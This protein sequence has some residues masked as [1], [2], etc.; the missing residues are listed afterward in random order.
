MSDTDRRQFMKLTGVG[1]AG[2]AL[3]TGTGVQTTATS[4]S[5]STDSI[6]TQEDYESFIA[7]SESLRVGV[8][9]TD[10]VGDGIE[11]GPETTEEAIYISGD[12]S[13]NSWSADTDDVG[14]P[15]LVTVLLDIIDRDEFDLFEILSEFVSE[16]D[17]ALLDAFI[18][19][20]IDDLDVRE[21]LSA[22]DTEQLFAPIVEILKGLDL[23]GDDERNG[24]GAGRQI[25]NELGWYLGIQETFENPDDLVEEDIEDLRFENT[26]VG[27]QVVSL[28][29]LLDG[30]EIVVIADELFGGK[31][32]DDPVAN[33]DSVD[34]LLTDPSVDKFIQLFDRIEESL[35]L[36]LL[37]AGQGDTLEILPQGVDFATED[38]PR[39][40]RIVDMVLAVLNSDEEF[41]TDL[42]EDDDN[43]DNGGNGSDFS[44]SCTAD[45]PVV[46]ESDD[47]DDGDLLDTIEEFLIEDLGLP[48]EF[49]DSE[50][51]REFIDELVDGI[52][53]PD[54][55]LG[56]LT[57]LEEDGSGFDAGY[58]GSVEELF[59]DP[60][61]DLFDPAESWGSEN[62]YNSVLAEIPD[63]I[64]QAL[65]FDAL[66][67]SDAGDRLDEVD[68]ILRG[69]LDEF[70]DDIDE[71]DNGLEL[72]V[73]IEGLS[74]DFDSDGTLLTASVD[75]VELELKTA[76]PEP[77]LVGDLI[78]AFLDD[79]EEITVEEGDETPN[80][81]A[82]GAD[83]L[84]DDVAFT[85]DEIDA[86]ESV[87]DVLEESLAQ[88]SAED[89]EEP[90]LGF[91]P[92]LLFDALRLL[93][94]DDEEN[95]DNGDN[96]DEDAGVFDIILDEL[97]DELEETQF[98]EFIDQFSDDDGEDP[99]WELEPNLE[100][101]SE[102]S[103]E[104]DGEFTVN[105]A[106][107]TAEVK[108]VEN[109]FTLDLGTLIDILTGADGETIGIEDIDIVGELE[110]VELTELSLEDLVTDE[111]DQEDWDELRDTFDDLLSG[112]S[113]DGFLEDENDP[114]TAVC[115]YPWGEDNDDG[116][117]SA[118]NEWENGECQIDSRDGACNVTFIADE[119]N[120]DLAQFIEE[121]VTSLATHIDTEVGGVENLIAS[122][123][124][125]LL[126]ALDNVPSY[127]EEPTGPSPLQRVVNIVIDLLELLVDA[128]D[129]GDGLFRDFTGAHAVDLEFDL[130]F[131]PNE[132]LV[133]GFD[134]PPRD[135]SR[136][137]RVEDINGDGQVDISDTQAL[138]DNMDSPAVQDNP[139]AFNFSNVS[140]DDEVTIFDVAAHWQRYVAQD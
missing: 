56:E 28:S 140:P 124:Y 40:D 91:L 63:V 31:T 69:E 44:V 103:G 11:V 75:G 24:E 29:A 89:G 62:Q 41:I 110:S 42:F 138:F 21:V 82:K 3:G 93:F 120:G 105:E 50:P 113:S 99:V 64:E 129:T 20:V 127:A 53:L 35:V 27:D 7:L 55:L 18:A 116:D 65:D 2:T 38:E 107:A 17:L 78:N 86:F 92:G 108:T 36:E 132:P 61:A 43:G 131:T 23:P 121:S 8:N 94:E 22:V 45:G 115:E 126:N 15:N 83:A 72:D 32:I 37:L 70:D 88:A 19:D 81:V 101:T 16:D 49:F 59:L 84:L 133:E 106:M 118:G 112:L 60:I 33:I 137:A 1:V 6:I 109:E 98:G 14:I 123:E 57:D 13:D 97:L 80:V 30:E 122:E 51:I 136:D 74:G 104:L 39:L 79:T 34:A 12:V 25:I 128:D 134:A 100:L 5:L 67:D 4:E 130:T 47:D 117:F 76:G 95:G 52:D 71:Y 58:I 73:G 48:E 77:E 10:P 111:L 90:D 125:G 66:E 54:D 9:T 135:I 139:A 68:A 119:Y 114:D 46:E 26:P 85:S 87:I 102:Q 96:G